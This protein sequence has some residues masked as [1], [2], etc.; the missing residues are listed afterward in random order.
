MNRLI[1]VYNADAGFF[2]MVT[3][4]AHKIFSPATYPCHLCDLTYGILKI[5]P[6]WDDF[7]KNAQIPLTFLHKD[8]FQHLFPD[9]KTWHLPAVFRENDAGILSEVISSGRLAEV[10]SVAELKELVSSRLGQ[11]A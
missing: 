4:I 1:F 7:V 11:S 8:E 5:R 9:W 3:D 10:Q 2:N 6:E